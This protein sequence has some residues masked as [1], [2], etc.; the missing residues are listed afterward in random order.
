[1]TADRPAGRLGAWPDRRQLGGVPHRPHS[2]AAMP[3]TDQV[4]LAQSAL[5]VVDAQ[6][7]F[8]ATPRWDRRDNLD[9]ET[10]V[11]ALVDAYRAAGLPV[12][13]FLH[14]DGDEGF[15]TD[16]PWFRLMDFLAPRADEPVLL[17][18][19]RNC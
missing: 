19:T 5:L 17:K 9:F 16:S 14:T 3:T 8:K 4:P 6:D 13:Y 1:M 2:E 7:S 10:N 15:A 12:F 18:S 11:A